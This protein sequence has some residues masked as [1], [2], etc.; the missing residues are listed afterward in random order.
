[1]A[2]EI[3]L[4]WDYHD[5]TPQLLEHL[6]AHLGDV[7]GTT[8]RSLSL[9]DL[10][11]GDLSPQTFPI[12]IRAHSEA[13]ARAAQAMQTAGISYGYYLDDNFWELPPGVPGADYWQSDEVRARSTTIFRGASPILVSTPP[14]RDFL[15]R[16]PELVPDARRVHQVDSFFDFALVPEL[17]APVSGRPR[18]RGGFASNRTPDLLLVLPDVLASLDRREDLEFE[19]IGGDPSALPR[20]PRLTWFPYEKS[21]DAYIRFQLVRAWDFGLAPLSDAP[22]NRYKTNNKF[23]EYAAVGIPGVYQDALPYIEV[24]DG[25]TGI[26]ASGPGTWSAAIESYLDSP[27]MRS[28]VREQ[29][30]RFAEDHFA[31]GVVAASWAE[32][33]SAAPEVGRRS[34]SYARA[35]AR[36][37]RRA[38]APGRLARLRREFASRGVRATTRRLF[39]SVRRRLVRGR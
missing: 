28:T 25:R 14:L 13:A 6:C 34:G 10:T 18:V 15:A 32:H 30:R 7:D 37:E 12:L 17:P 35:R 19:V 4:L 21:Y 8:Y 1:M 39:D 36:L 33:L 24:D 16:H 5:A 20:H 22:S 29:A 31:I 38:S 3:L 2:L 11:P 23:R 27:E 9:T 26:R